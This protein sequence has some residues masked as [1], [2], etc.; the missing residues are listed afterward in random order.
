MNRPLVRIFLFLTLAVVLAA[1]VE[2]L[3]ELAREWE[4]FRIRSVEV[5]GNHFIPDS[6]VVAALGLVPGSSI[7]DR[8]GGWEGGVRSHPVVNE[9]RVRR[10]FPGALRVEVEERHPVA[11]LPGAALVPVD[12]TGRRLPLEQQALAGLDLPVIP[13]SLSDRELEQLAG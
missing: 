10:R 5:V 7:L 3:T 2:P 8:R 1:G 11:F 13:A 6:Q 9:A 4:F 12:G